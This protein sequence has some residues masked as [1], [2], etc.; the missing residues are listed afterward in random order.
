MSKPQQLIAYGC[1]NNERNI[2]VDGQAGKLHSLL[3]D[4]PELAQQYY[5]RNA[6]LGDV[7]V[8]VRCEAVCDVEVLH[9]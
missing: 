8:K 1:W 5:S 7:I 3:F 6:S 4:T 2:S 9:V